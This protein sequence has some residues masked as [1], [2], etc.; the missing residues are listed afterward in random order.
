VSA[1][2]RI[3]AIVVLLVAAL[4]PTARAQVT[5]HGPAAEEQT[6]T[7]IKHVVVLMQENHSFDNYFGTYPGADG[8]PEGTCMPYDS[9]DPSKGCVK[10]FHLAGRAVEDMIHTKIAFDLQLNEGAMDGFVE[11]TQELNPAAP[12]NK[13]T[14]GYYDDRDLPFYWNV[15]DNFV[16]F[17]RFFTS[18]RGGSVS[19]HLFWVAGQAGV[20]DLD[21]ETIPDGGFEVPTIFDRLEEKGVSWKFYVQNYDPRITFR[22]RVVGDRGAQ[23]VWNP[24]LAMAR[25]LDRPELNGRIVDIE[26]YYEDLA[27]GTLPAV[28]YIV[29]SGSSEHPP[30]SIQAGQTFVRNLI[31][32]L[33]RSS[34]WKK[35]AFMWTYDDWGGWY[36]HVKPPQVDEFG[37]GFRA[38]ML[39]VSPFAKKGFIDSTETDFTSFLR[40]IEEN[41][42]VAPLASRD[43]QAGTLMN[44]FDFEAPPR[45]PEFVGLE[46]NVE[47]PPKPKREVIYIAYLLGLAVAGTLIASTAAAARRPKRRREADKEEREREEALL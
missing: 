7:P 31:G 17:D 44:A 15:A 6:K 23:I 47:P 29:P 35:S 11:A 18:S 34:A 36:D 16:L 1:L 38:P 12:P 2:R 24:L 3:A 39:L 22:S 32:S 26:E 27:N 45:E 13:N 10:P 20:P 43:K 9:E 4:A 19:N 46:R 42:G 21:K 25:F 41:W 30:G 37:Y 8:V 28:A 14:M 5:D 33:Q 40:F